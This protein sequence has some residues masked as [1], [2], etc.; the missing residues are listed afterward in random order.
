MKKPVYKLVVGMSVYLLIFA[1]NA[2]AMRD[3]MQS[4]VMAPI[5]VSNGAVVSTPA[6]SPSTFILVRN[7]QA[8]FI[9][10]G[11]HMAVGSKIKS[12]TIV[13]IEETGVWVKPAGARGELR[14]IPLYKKVERHW[15]DLGLDKTNEPEH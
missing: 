10:Q 1:S 7:G 2:I 8:F 3:P 6:A 5:D 11:R 15:A 13:R 9:D 12:G 4:P 14:K